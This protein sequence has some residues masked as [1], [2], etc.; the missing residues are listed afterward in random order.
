MQH[1]TD[2]SGVVQA[3]G[4][5]R[6]AGTWAAIFGGLFLF[7]GFLVL[8]IADWQQSAGYVVAS[9]PGPLVLQSIFLERAAGELLAGVGALLG[10]IGLGLA[11]IEA[12]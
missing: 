9:G 6:T 1:G 5:W 8:A 11:V 3:S 2:S 4:T 10:F 7:V 12:R